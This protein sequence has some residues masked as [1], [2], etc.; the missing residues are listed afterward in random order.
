MAK[1]INKESAISVFRAKAEMATCTPAQPYFYKAVK[2]LEL[3][4][5]ADVAPVRHGRWVWHETGDN[6]WE[7]FYSCSN[8]GEKS[9]W[10]SNFCQECG[11][12][13]DL[14]VSDGKSENVRL[15]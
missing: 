15:F 7:Q 4:P 9:Y 11:A 2:M 13:M 1:Y 12:K 3:L 5:A 6:E 10:E 8:C 14:E